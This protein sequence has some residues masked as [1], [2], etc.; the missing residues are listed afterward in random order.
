MSEATL[1]TL[2]LSEESASSRLRLTTEAPTS[3]GTAFEPAHNSLGE[4]VLVCTLLCFAPIPTVEPPPSDVK[5]LMKLWLVPEPTV[6]LTPPDFKPLVKLSFGSIPSVGPPPSD[7]KPLLTPWIGPVG[8]WPSDLQA[9]GLSALSEAICARSTPM[10]VAT[11]S[12][13]P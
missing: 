8:L 7:V 4:R 1:T 10:L 13:C 11:P 9:M 2:E 3:G 6:V 5:P 12:R